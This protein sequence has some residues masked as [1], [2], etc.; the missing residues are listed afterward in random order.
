MQPVSVSSCALRDLPF[1]ERKAILSAVGVTQE[2]AHYTPD[3][4]GPSQEFL[5]DTIHHFRIEKDDGKVIKLDNTVPGIK[6]L[7]DRLI[8]ESVSRLLP[9]CRTML[10]SGQTIA[11]GRLSVEPDGLS[12]RIRQLSWSN[13]SGVQMLH[14]RIVIES[15][16]L[17]VWDEVNVS[18]I[19]NALVFLALCQEHI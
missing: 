7:G 8:Q 12:N 9:I 13:L 5:V 6:E 10:Q 14:G 4:F 17:G 15:K 1:C 16:S 18:S 2:V 3:I 19:P 11:F